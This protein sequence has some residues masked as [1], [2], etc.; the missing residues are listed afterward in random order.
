MAT[1]DVMI[2]AAVRAMS[3]QERSLLALRQELGYINPG[4]R[5]LDLRYTAWRRELE[6]HDPEMEPFRRR[7]EFAP[8]ATDPKYD[9]WERSKWWI[10]CP[11]DLPAE[12][13]GFFRNDP[14]RGPVTAY[15][16]L[17]AERH[18]DCGGVKVVIGP[19]HFGCTACATQVKLWEHGIDDAPV[20]TAGLRQ[21]KVG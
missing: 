3:R 14:K 19:S 13:R 6:I 8:L 10:P 21:Q 15:M 4:L 11:A 17:L 7:A 9:G 12:L 2:A 20:T 1:N 16:M 5:E 18:P